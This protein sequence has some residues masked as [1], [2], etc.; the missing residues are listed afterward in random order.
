MTT[1][2]IT[3]IV[4]MLSACAA[5]TSSIVYESQ[6]C[7]TGTHWCDPFSTGGDTSCHAACGDLNAYCPPVFNACTEFESSDSRPIDCICDGPGRV[8]RCLVKCVVGHPL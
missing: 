3:T 1:A 8:L 2:I 5:D 4:A 6:V 7:S